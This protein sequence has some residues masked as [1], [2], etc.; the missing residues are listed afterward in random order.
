MKHIIILGD[1][2]A[3]H[4]V[5]RLGGKT[6]LQYADTPY[7][8]LLARKG[9]T[10]RLMTIPDGFHPGSEVANTSILGYDLNKVYEGR[11]PLEAA[12]IGYNMSP[13][14]LALRCN[15]ITLSD[16]IIKNHHGGHLTTEEGTTL[17]KYL[18]EKLGNEYIQFIPGIQ[19]RHLLIIKGGSKHIICAPPHDHPNEAWKPLLIKAEN[20]NKE[21]GRLSPQETA[22]LLN[23]LIIK[24]Q[25]LLTAHPFNLQRKDK[26]NDIANSI[27]PWG[28][29]YRP[30]MR[31]LS[32]MFPQVHS[33]S[34]ISAVDLIRGIGYYA[35]LE[36]IKVK[37]ATGL[38]NTNYEGKVEAALK[39]L[40][41]KDFV[42]L[43]IEASD[44]AGHDG[45]LQLKLQTI[46]N[47]DHRAVEPIYNEIKKWDEPVCIAVLPDH[48]T[49]V[50]IRTHVKEPVPFLIWHP[51]I[52]PDNVTQYDETSCV[53]GEYG[54]IYLQEFMHSLMEIK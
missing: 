1:G 49:P 31:T 43:H 23:E 14:D 5:E 51:G 28:G 12:S 32:E 16:G 13:E 20:E 52:T 36:I 29:G 40:R 25:E 48:P 18:N 41:E 15:L 9:K 4:P 7:M 24:S 22:N 10:G 8:D 53:R 19:Y 39:Q 35:G 11:G 50:E 45:D 54:L 38:A 3:D 17:I 37:G 27:W 30:Q 47:L 33:G 46:E 34:V 26:Q 44:E 21:D 2:M 42:F 6:L